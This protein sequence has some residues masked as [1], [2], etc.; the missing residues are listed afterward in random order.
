MIA[1]A[2]FV[3]A[4]VGLRPPDAATKSKNPAFSKPGRNPLNFRG[5]LFKQ[6][7]PALQFRIEVPW[8]AH[9]RLHNLSMER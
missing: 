7:E 6:P 9:R 1:A 4:L 3:A 2:D 8:L 5:A